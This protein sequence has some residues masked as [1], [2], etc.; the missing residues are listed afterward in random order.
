MAALYHRLMWRIAVIVVLLSLSRA[1]SH[2]G[3]PAGYRCGK[4]KPAA[5]KGC[6]CIAGEVERRDAENIA[7]CFAAQP[8]VA[9]APVAVLGL[10]GCDDVCTAACELD[11]AHACEASCTAGN[12]D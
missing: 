3:P 12:A 1:P 7:E 9:P 8:R 2:A 10:A 5:G 6:A 11:D 4:G